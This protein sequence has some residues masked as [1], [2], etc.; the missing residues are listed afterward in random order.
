M[1]VCREV[2]TEVLTTMIHLSYFQCVLSSA[3]N[4]EALILMFR[5]HG[6]SQDRL[7]RKT[8]HIDIYLSNPL[9][10]VAAFMGSFI[11]FVSKQT[12]TKLKINIELQKGGRTIVYTK[13][14]VTV[15]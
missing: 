10:V 15:R 14:I 13:L 11:K 6:I 5:I 9:T 8:P 3:S 7:S 2:N 12:T 1:K 4:L